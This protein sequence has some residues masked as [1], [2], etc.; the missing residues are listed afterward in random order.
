M[1]ISLCLF[2]LGISCIVFSRFQRYSIVACCWTI[3]AMTGSAFLM[4]RSELCTDVGENPNCSMDQGGLAALAGVVLWMLT[5]VIGMFFVQPVK[6]KKRNPRL[7]EQRRKER[8]AQMLNMLQQL[9]ELEQMTKEQNKIKARNERANLEQALEE[10]GSRRKLSLRAMPLSRKSSE[11]MFNKVLKRSASAPVGQWH[12]PESIPNDMPKRAGSKRN[13]KSIRKHKQ[14]ESPKGPPQRSSCRRTDSL[15]DIYEPPIDPQSVYGTRMHP[16]KKRKLVA[17]ARSSSLLDHESVLEPPKHN[18]QSRLP[19][20]SV[21]G[22]LGRPNARAR[23][24]AEFDEV[25]GRSQSKVFGRSQSQPTHPAY[26]ANRIGRSQSRPAHPAYLANRILSSQRGH[27]S[28]L[29][30]TRDTT[31]APALMTRDL[32]TSTVVNDRDVEQDVEVYISDKLNRIDRMMSAASED[33]D[34]EG[35]LCEV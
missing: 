14:A 20:R 32:S 21:G 28:G 16:V 13:L 6:N 35:G 26:L 31:S 5:S 10:A 3:A 2:S 19:S 33:D 25:F 12:S 15:L 17:G 8:K 18:R 34:L 24:Q 22:K 4:T 30:G 9:E 11:K 29:R 7:R 1:S 23:D 27:S